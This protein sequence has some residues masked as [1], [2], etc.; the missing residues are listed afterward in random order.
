MFQE[1]KMQTFHFFI[2]RA[3]YFFILHKRRN[4]YISFIINKIY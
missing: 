2:S 1:G 3:S 4:I